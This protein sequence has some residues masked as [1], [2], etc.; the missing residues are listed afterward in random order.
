[1]AGGYLAWER[2]VAF[3]CCLPVAS[4]FV[5]RTHPLEIA[6]EVVVGENTADDFEALALVH[7]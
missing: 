7:H 6:V 2:V 5:G 4:G 3:Q 1:M